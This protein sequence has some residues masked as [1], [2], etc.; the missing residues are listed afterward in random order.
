MAEFYN[1]NEINKSTPILNIYANIHIYK[2]I[3]IVLNDEPFHVYDKSI[4]FFSKKEYDN[5]FEVN[6]L[7]PTT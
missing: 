6:N 1:K 7:T 3:G 4:R 2:D 5:F